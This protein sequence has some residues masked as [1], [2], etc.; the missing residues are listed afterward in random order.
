MSDKTCRSCGAPV[1]WAHHE[2]S[3]KAAP[4][5]AEPSDAGNVV[6][7]PPDIFGAPR[8]RVLGPAS[9]GL[10]AGP[11]HTSHFMTCPQAKQWRGGA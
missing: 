9:V 2:Q 8:Y 5:D 4:I 6:L 1:I 7:L 3:G 10:E 11:R